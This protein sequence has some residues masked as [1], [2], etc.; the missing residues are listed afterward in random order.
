MR[1]KI[2]VKAL[3]KLKKDRDGLVVTYGTATNVICVPNSEI[4]CP[5]KRRRKSAETLS[6]VRSIPRPRNR[7]SHPGCRASGG[8]GGGSSS[9]WSS[10]SPRSSLTRPYATG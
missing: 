2:T 1:G 10:G 8:T 9:S 7:P 4:A 3:Q 6:G 5:T